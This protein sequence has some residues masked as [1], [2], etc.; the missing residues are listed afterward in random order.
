MLRRVQHNLFSIIVRT[1]IA[2]R[3]RTQ[4]CIEKLEDR[5]HPRSACTTAN[6]LVGNL[7]CRLHQGLTESLTC[8]KHRRMVTLAYISNAFCINP[9]HG[10]NRSLNDTML[11]MKSIPYNI[12]TDPGSN[13]GSTKSL[14]NCL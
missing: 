9:M 13:K 1:N 7:I 10:S 12:W 3:N 11:F 2:E 8:V 6:V 14:F 5:G 4:Q